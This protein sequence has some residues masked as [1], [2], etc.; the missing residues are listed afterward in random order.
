MTKKGEMGH[1]EINK[2]QIYKLVIRTMGKSTYLLQK[3]LCSKQQIHSAKLK[4][5]RETMVCTA[6]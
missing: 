3:F 4:T 2:N 5:K 6:R 1:L